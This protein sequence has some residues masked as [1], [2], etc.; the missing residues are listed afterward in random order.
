MARQ[1]RNSGTKAIEAKEKAAR[2]LEL[3]KEGK[4]FE[5][6]AKEAGYS[7]RQ[8]AYDAVKRAMAAITRE[9]AVE[10]IELELARL[11]S[12][13]GSYYIKAQAG[14]VLALEA[15][16]K[17]MQRRAKLIGLD[18]PSE[19]RAEFSGPDG[20]PVAMPTIIQLVGVR[21]QQ[22]AEHDGTDPG[23]DHPAG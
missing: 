20:G 7:C 22:Q 5:E 1:D 4:T 8:S 13:W 10:L 14:N 11:D 9:P 3:R 6:I 2:A 21:P 17:I 23:T 12:M 15:C 19:S 18:A 16:L